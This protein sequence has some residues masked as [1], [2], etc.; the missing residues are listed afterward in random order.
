[1]ENGLEVFSIYLFNNHKIIS[2]LS[3]FTTVT[4]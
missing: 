1:M 2:L 3:K 4:I